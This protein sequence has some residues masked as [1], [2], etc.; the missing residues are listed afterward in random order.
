VRARRRGR[1]QRHD[2]QRDERT[3]YMGKECTRR[4]K[5]DACISQYPVC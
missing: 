2:G 4:R 3:G 5:A 1:E